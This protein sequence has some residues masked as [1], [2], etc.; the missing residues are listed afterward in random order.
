MFVLLQHLV[1]ADQSH[2]SRRSLEVFPSCQIYPVMAFFSS[3]PHLCC[4]S[5]SHS[6]CFLEPF[7]VRLAEFVLHNSHN[8]CM[9]D[10]QMISGRKMEDMLNAFADRVSKPRLFLTDRM[11]LAL[12]TN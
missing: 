8:E 5:R 10:I 2:S 3:Y 1:L 9:I 11:L 12:G 7:Q 6:P 4:L